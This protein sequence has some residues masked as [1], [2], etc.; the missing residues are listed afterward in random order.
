MQMKLLRILFYT[1]AAESTLGMIAT[2]SSPVPGAENS[3][4]GAAYY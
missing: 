2:Y 3:V 1:L 4:L